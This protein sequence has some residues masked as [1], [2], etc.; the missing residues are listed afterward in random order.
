M[1]R[2]RPLLWQSLPCQSRRR[3][4]LS[5]GASPAPRAGLRDAAVQAAY[6][7]PR[8]ALATP[9]QK[10]KSG[11]T[12]QTPRPGRY[13]A[14]CAVQAWGRASDLISLSQSAEERQG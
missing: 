10:S 9:G 14:S 12:W 2:G 7:S 3:S 4:G 11:S 6:A 1:P 8:S 13:Y 5:S